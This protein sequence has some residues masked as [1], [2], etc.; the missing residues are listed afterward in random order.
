MSKI[1]EEMA[2]QDYKRLSMPSRERLR[3][4]V[5]AEPHMEVEA[6]GY[7]FNDEIW[8]KDPLPEQA[9]GSGGMNTYLT[10]DANRVRFEVE[11]LLRAFPELADDDD[12][13]AD[14]LEGETE[15]DSVLTRL[16]LA[17][18]HKEEMANGAKAI[19]DDLDARIK[20]NQSGAAGLKNIIHT[21]MDTAKLN[22]RELAVAT[23]SVLAGRKRVVVDDVNALPQG[24]YS[25]ERKPAPAK[26]LE[27]M[28]MEAPAG[29]FPGASIQ[30]GPEYL[31]VRPK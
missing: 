31:Y 19:R 2:P 24:A 10:L 25:L 26:E 20:R 30:L 8:G 9:K 4:K 11:A 13:R 7:W 16:F 27:K 6:R 23:I 28:I 15:I 3:E 1:K 22:K 5:I 21:L 29:Q 17:M 18:R 12:L 14:V